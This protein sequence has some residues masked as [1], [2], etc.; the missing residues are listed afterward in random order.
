MIIYYCYSY[1]IIDQ[2][3]ISLDRKRIALIFSD[4][5]KKEQEWRH[6]DG[7]ANYEWEQAIIREWDNDQEIANEYEYIHFHDADGNNRNCRYN[8]YNYDNNT[9]SLLLTYC[10]RNCNYNCNC[11][12]SIH[13]KVIWIEERLVC[14]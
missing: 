8:S 9:L 10:N 14:I 5:F 13:D 1:I 2:Y 4:N 11:N 6:G 7:K 3:N 12:G